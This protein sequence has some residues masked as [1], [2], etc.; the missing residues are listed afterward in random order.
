MEKLKEKPQIIVGSSGRILELITKNKIHAKNIDVIVLDEADMMFDEDFL[1]ILD[2]VLP[3]MT[4][5]KYLLFSASITQGM[6]PFIKKYF[7]SY[8]LIDTFKSHNLK[9]DYQLLN[10]KYQNRLDALM[11][12]LENINPYL[13]FIFVSKKENQEP[14]FQSL[15]E[16]G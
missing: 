9:I 13:C 15:Q 11:Q 2:H 6:E 3:S 1:S 12:V 16:K 7:G 10:I 14:V 8:E 4:K 5:A